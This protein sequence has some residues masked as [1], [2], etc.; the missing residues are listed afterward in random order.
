MNNRQHPQSVYTY[1]NNDNLSWVDSVYYKVIDT[2]LIKK[3]DKNLTFPEQK[4][5]GNWIDLRASKVKTLF[6]GKWEFLDLND[7]PYTYNY[8]ETLLI[9]LGISIDLQG[10]EAI[11]A[12][13][14]STFKNFGL[15]QTNSIGVIDSSYCGDDD[16]W[17]FPC[18]A[19]RQGTL[20]H[21]DRICQFRILNPMPEIHI[22][23]VEFLNNKNRGG[24]GSTG[25]K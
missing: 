3:H 5:N 1:T 8:G 18:Y 10:K 9:D 13:R 20:R 4:E 7:G 21:N 17:Y 14:S 16:K 6:Q 23:L 15:I 25:I 22:E 11:V 12:P 24:L 19:L 2:I